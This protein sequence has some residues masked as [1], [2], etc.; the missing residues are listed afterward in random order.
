M[1]W[2]SHPPC[3]A[4]VS[5]ITVKQV[6][7]RNKHS[8]SFCLSQGTVPWTD[9]IVILPLGSMPPP[10]TRPLLCQTSFAAVWLCSVSSLIRIYIFGYYCV[11]V[12]KVSQKG[13]LKS[14][15]TPSLLVLYLTAS[16]ASFPSSCYRTPNNILFWSGCVIAG[17]NLSANYG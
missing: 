11:T 2:T 4:S 17:G 12:Y 3:W 14:S 8:G 10:P 1:S 7:E 9:L 5:P 16:S 6:G 15:I 13:C